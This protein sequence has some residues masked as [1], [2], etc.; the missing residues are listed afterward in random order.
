M[1]NSFRDRLSRFFDSGWYPAL[2]AA[3]CVLSGVNGKNVY[4]PVAGVLASL[5]IL[6]TFFAKKRRSFI[7]PVLLSFYCIGVDNPNGFKDN[8]AELLGY[9]DLNSFLVVCAVG[10][11]GAVFLLVRLIKM[12]VFRRE[13]QGSCSFLW[14]ILLMDGAFLFNGIGS[15]DWQPVNLLYGLIFSVVLTFFYFLFRGCLTGSREDREFVCRITVAMSLIAMLQLIIVYTIRY[16]SGTLFEY[17]HL[18]K[19]WYPDRDAASLGWGIATSV[20]GILVL[21][22][23][24]AMYMAAIRRRGWIWYLAA[25]LLA[26]VSVIPRSRMAV[27]VAFAFLA[28]GMLLGCI[29]GANKKQ[30]RIITVTL[31]VLATVAMIAGEAAGWLDL[32]A[33]AA[34]T[35]LEALFDG[36]RWNMWRAAWNHMCSAPI[37]GVGFEKGAGVLEMRANNVFSNM[38]HGIVPQF[39]GSMGILGVTAFGWHLYELSRAVLRRFTVEKLFFLLVPAMILTMSMVDNFFFYANYQF[40]YCL[41]L[42]LIERNERKQ[43]Q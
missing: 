9:Y 26:M 10:V 33:V 27:I 28:L 43:Q 11:A 7:A 12:G 42:A 19:T 2:Y 40:V 29:W 34:Y 4:V 22:I 21:G 1:E 38:Y 14:G 13:N 20:S 37:L 16:H 41:F 8:N 31:V 18:T 35:R 39:G 5:I 17:D 25:L 36:P 23:P 24:A 30:N 15:P 32:T 3:L 6:S